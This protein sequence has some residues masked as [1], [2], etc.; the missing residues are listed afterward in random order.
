MASK[1]ITI[2]TEV[3]E[4][5]KGVK[6]KQES[7][8]DLLRRLVHQI[9]GQKLADFFGAWEMDDKEYDEIQKKIHSIPK[10]RL[11]KVNFD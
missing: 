1:T 7:F 4:L 10:F 5:L 6:Q 3:Y 9:N 11:E 8:S 2:T